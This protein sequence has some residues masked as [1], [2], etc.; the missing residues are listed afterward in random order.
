MEHLYFK[1]G[2]IN[3][4]NF[5]VFL[6]QLRRKIGDERAF[7]FMDNLSVHKAKKLL[8]IYDDLDF[9]PVFNIVATPDFNAI[10]TCFA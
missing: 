4:N 10:E 7:L 9:D 8:N 6:R 5:K 2:A 3:A 1:A